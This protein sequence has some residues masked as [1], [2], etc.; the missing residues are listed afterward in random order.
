MKSAH[1]VFIVLFFSAILLRHILPPLVPRQHWS[2]VEQNKL[3]NKSF[4]KHEFPKLD[5]L[6]CRV[7]CGL[8]S[9]WV[10]SRLVSSRSLTRCSH[11]ALSSSLISLD[12]SEKGW[13]G[14]VKLK[15]K[16]FK[17]ESWKDPEKSDTLDATYKSSTENYHTYK[18][19][20]IQMHLLPLTY[21]RKVKDLVLISFI[22]FYTDMLTLVS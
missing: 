11:Q 7:S 17:A 1:T 14:I 10:L 5:L 20:F 16:F 12:K 13:D 18:E 8:C 19:R 21:N 22:R 15:L 6:S 9:F 2:S 3:R 4:T